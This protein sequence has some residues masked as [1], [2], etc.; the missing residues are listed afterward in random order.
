[1]MEF[2]DRIRRK[3]P[4]VRAHYAFG[5]A[6]FFTG[7]IALVWVT[8]L[9]TRLSTISNTIQEGNIPEAGS[10][11]I[12]FD[13]LLQNMGEGLQDTLNTEEEPES[14]PQTESYSGESS[15]NDLEGWATENEDFEPESPSS[16]PEEQGANEPQSS[17][18]AQVIL[19]GTTT[20]K[21]E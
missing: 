17:T 19:I 6:L 14:L 21:T 2:L 10:A 18:S 20:K 5:S 9:P 16:A 7:V 1:M 4:H 13:N 3:P 8:T 11:Q 15:L 12:G